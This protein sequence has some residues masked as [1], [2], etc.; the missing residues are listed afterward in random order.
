[1]IISRTPLRISFF[2]GGS[3]YPVYV[4]RHGGIT[5]A[6]AIDKY[7]YITLHK[8]LPVKKFYY[9]FFY[10][11]IE[12]CNEI[13]EILHPSIRESLRFMENK[14]RLEGH[15][16]ADLPARSGLG[17][18]SA[19]TVG[20]LHAL[21]ILKGKCP[22]PKQVAEDAVF[23]EQQLIRERVGSQDQYACALGGMNLLKFQPSGDVDAYPVPNR[24]FS[25]LHS[26][27]LLFY[28]GVQ[29]FAHDIL[30]EQEQNTAMGKNDVPL[31]ELKQLALEGLNIL[32]SE[33][34]I[35]SFGHLLDIAWNLKQ[36]CSGKIA[37]D[38][39]RKQYMIA[40][41]NGAI[42]GK[43][44]GAGGGG[45]FLIFANPDCHERLK[46]KLFP[47]VHIP[48]QF[49]ANGTEIIFRQDKYESLY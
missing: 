10:S 8:L 21:Q 46:E 27:L 24:R 7:I 48:F 32:S 35:D 13:D 25:E 2:G 39:I 29:R 31:E 45:F 37:N 22:A 41:D 44:L 16:T 26:C 1:M 23:V 4:K 9:T 33:T 28:T 14:I 12:E 20:F 49:A 5:L 40:K 18:S 19:F 36:A 30:A 47:W 34:P 6:T 42:G 43:L 38:M 11:K 15:V 3:D 17:S